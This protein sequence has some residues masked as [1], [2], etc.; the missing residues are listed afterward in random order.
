[1]VSTI[2]LISFLNERLSAGHR[3][4]P[5]ETIISKGICF[6][7][8]PESYSIDKKE[9]Y[10]H[11]SIIKICFI[12]SNVPKPALR[13]HHYQ[14]PHSY[15]HQNYRFVPLVQTGPEK[16]VSSAHIVSLLYQ[17]WQLSYSWVDY[18]SHNHHIK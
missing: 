13:D 14:V 1:M 16:T 12:I 4:K 10:R 6:L 15:R 7:R 18:L 9:Y 8:V 2:N 3:R 5:P 17:V 11:N